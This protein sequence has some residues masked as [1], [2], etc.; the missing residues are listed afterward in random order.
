[1][2]IGA[3]RNHPGRHVIAAR[4]AP[5]LTALAAARAVSA[6]NG[7]VEDLYLTNMGLRFGGDAAAA[8]AVAEK[9]RS[10]GNP[11]VAV[12]IIRRWLENDARATKRHA[13]TPRHPAVTS[14]PGSTIDLTARVTTRPPRRTVHS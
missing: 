10:T 8:A 6:D 4:P 3:R 13:W 2:G 7:D 9:I 12:P 1:L 14:V 5:S 11:Y